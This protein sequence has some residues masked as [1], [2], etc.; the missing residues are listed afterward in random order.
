MIPVTKL[1]LDGM[2][3]DQ[4]PVDDIEL[5]HPRTLASRIIRTDNQGKEKEKRDEKEREKEKKRK[6]PYLGRSRPAERFKR[7]RRLPLA[8]LA[9][10]LQRHDRVPHRKG[11]LIQSPPNRLHK[12][13]LMSD[14]LRNIRRDGIQ[15]AGQGHPVV[16]VET[17]QQHVDEGADHV[18]DGG[19]GHV[20]VGGHVAEDDVG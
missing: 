1:G 18:R 20:S 11:R 9:G 3:T 4:D 13:V 7:E 10:I 5:F 12:P 19:D 15:Q 2:M 17:A 8:L 6:E 16:N 14:A